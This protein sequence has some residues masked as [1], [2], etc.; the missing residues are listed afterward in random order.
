MSKID[1]AL[2]QARYVPPMMWTASVSVRNAILDNST[3][4]GNTINDV[5]EEENDFFS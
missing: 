5:D 1:M 4:E 2:E 3:V